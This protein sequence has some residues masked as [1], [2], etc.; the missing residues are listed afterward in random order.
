MQK[1]KWTE[2]ESQK[3]KKYVEEK[4][5]KEDT[6]ESVAQAVGLGRSGTSC[7]ERYENHLRKDLIPGPFLREEERW[8]WE[9]HKERKYV[10]N[11][12]PSFANTFL[13]L[14]IIGI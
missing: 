1:P 4:K 11:L 7:R 14:L 13:L 6:W 2:E 8:I 3:L 12:N 9:M 5:Q 10:V